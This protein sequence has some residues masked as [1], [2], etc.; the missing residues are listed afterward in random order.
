MKDRS[1]RK[2][3]FLNVWTPT[4]KGVKEAGYGLKLSIRWVFFGSHH[5]FKHMS[6]IQALLT[7][8]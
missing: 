1:I 5:L 2:T 8:L 6:S 4:K 7:Q 3:Q